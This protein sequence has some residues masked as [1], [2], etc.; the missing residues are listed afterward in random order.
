MSGFNDETALEIAAP[1]LPP[2][3]SKRGRGRPPVHDEA[4]TKV[5]VVLFDRQIAFLDGVAARIRRESGVPVSRAQVVRALVDATAEAGVDLTAA[6]SEADMKAM[7]L[8]RLRC[9][10]P[11]Q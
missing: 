7:M 1:S 3:R 4:W 9:R 5:T 11:L 10:E 6:A 8:E 2:V